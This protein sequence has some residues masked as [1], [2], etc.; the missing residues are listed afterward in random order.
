MAWMVETLHD[1]VRM[2]VEAESVLYDS[3]T[4][5]QRLVIFDNPTLGRVMMLDDIVQTTEADEFVYH[6]ML[7]HVPL[8]GHGDARTVLI[9]GG[10]DGGT[11][12]EVLKHKT[13]DRATLVE[14]DR[15]VV[16]I[17]REYLPTICG[18]AFDD[19]RTDLVIDDGVAFVGRD[20][21]RYDVMIIDST[22]PV[23]PGEALFSGQ[24]YA[25]CKN[26]LNPGG[27]L[28]TQNGVPFYQGDELTATARGL[29]PI[30]RDVSCYLAA[31]PMYVGG[32]MAFGWAS[33]DSDLRSVSAATLETRFAAAD[34]A[35]R[36]YTPAVHS[37]AFA[38]PPYIAALMG[39]QSGSA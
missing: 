32:V 8:L 5:H 37:G 29:R 9:I 25:A 3:A 1:G 7:A 20:G 11:L 12:E 2:Q 26:R 24:F 27:V 13:V 4:E 21:E 14:I 33:D 35:T 19:P 28:V 16:D 38:V 10:G 18:G 6:E 22:D 23:G 30:F 15:A 36:Y 17:S 34:I 39:N 31:V